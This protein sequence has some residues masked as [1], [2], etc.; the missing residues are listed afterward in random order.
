MQVQQGI[1]ALHPRQ[2]FGG[3]PKLVASVL[4]KAIVRPDTIQIFIHES[5][6]IIVLGIETIVGAQIAE[7]QD[8]RAVPGP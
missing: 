2:E 7:G 8:Q 4:T 1:G 3:T 6:F 5:A